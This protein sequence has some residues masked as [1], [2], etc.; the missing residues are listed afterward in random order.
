[1][2]RPRCRQSGKIRFDTH[3]QAL[4]RAG[5]IAT[6]WRTFSAYPCRACHGYH[7]TTVSLG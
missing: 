5:E 6:R 7:L 4:T 3:E 2:K 1:M